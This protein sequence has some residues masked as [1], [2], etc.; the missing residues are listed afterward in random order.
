MKYLKRLKSENEYNAFLGGGEYIE[1]HVVT[2]EENA[3]VFLKKAESKKKIN[4]VR[5][6]TPSGSGI[7]RTIVSSDGSGNPPYF[8]YP[9]TSDIY[10]EFN[11][12]T[13]QRLFCQIGNVSPSTTQYWPTGGNLITNWT[14][15][16]DDTYIYQVIVE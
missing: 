13:G 2:I 14:P 11:A 7:L 6:A 10:I 12:G 4:T 9:V 5:I 15:K 16:E 8:E 3:K 1:P